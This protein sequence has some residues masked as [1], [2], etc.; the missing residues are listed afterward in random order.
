MNNPFS[1]QNQYGGF[2]F[3]GYGSN[4]ALTAA[5]AAA[6]QEQEAEKIRIN[7]R[8]KEEERLAKEEE[9]SKKGELKETKQKQS[10]E[11]KI[12]EYSRIFGRPIKESEI[13]G[14]EAQLYPPI[15]I[16]K[17]TERTTNPYSRGLQ[18]DLW[19]FHERNLKLTRREENPEEWDRRIREQIEL[20]GKIRPDK[21]I[22]EQG[23]AATQ[24]MRE[25]Q[26]ASRR[27]TPSLTGLF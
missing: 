1:F 7:L 12:A 4:P 22:E 5:R 2:A 8:Q 25:R 24:A 18:G 17:K 13:E 14:I 26:R 23:R 3:T 16:T 6:F 9:K 21:T 19:K 10:T 15:K 27:M 11:R 20:E